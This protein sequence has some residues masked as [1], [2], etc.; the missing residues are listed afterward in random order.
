MWLFNPVSQFWYS[1]RFD[2][3]R[4]STLNQGTGVYAFDSWIRNVRRKGIKICGQFHD[5]HI[6]PVLKGNEEAHKGKLLLA[7]DETNNELQLN[8]KLGIS[9]DFGHSYSEIH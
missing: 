7:I 6:A 5:E 9:I 2:K 1:L 3:D 8:V 4:F